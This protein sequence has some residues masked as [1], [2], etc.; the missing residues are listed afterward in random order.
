MS[1]NRSSRETLWIPG[2]LNSGD[3]VDY[4]LGWSIRRTGQGTVVG[5]GG[6]DPSGFRSRFRRFLRDN[7]TIILFCNGANSDP[8]PI[9]DAIAQRM[10]GRLTKVHH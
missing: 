1:L 8:K 2:R 10:H 6:D 4:G 9:V 5:H 7:L 3:R